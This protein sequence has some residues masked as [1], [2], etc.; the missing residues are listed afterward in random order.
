M[1]SKMKIDTTMHDLV[2]EIVTEE[3]NEKLETLKA[4]DRAQQKPSQD[5][6]P[7]TPTTGPLKSSL[8]EAE[9]T[10]KQRAREAAIVKLKQAELTREVN[11]TY[12]NAALE[13]MTSN[14]TPLVSMPPRAQKM[15]ASGCALYYEN[16]VDRVLVNYIQQ[17]QLKRP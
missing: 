3:G 1:L 12:L 5:A 16:F 10:D 15:F 14:K 13:L 6:S 4:L 9:E 7:A 8:F 11:V 17:R 2:G